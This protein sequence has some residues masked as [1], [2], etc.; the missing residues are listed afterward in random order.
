MV[1]IAHCIYV[2][3]DDNTP[4]IEALRADSVYHTCLLNIARDES[5]MSD[6]TEASNTLNTESVISLRVLTCGTLMYCPSRL[7]FGLCIY[8]LPPCRY[9]KEYITSTAALGRGACGSRSNN[10]PSI[11]WTNPFNLTVRRVKC[12]V[13]YRFPIS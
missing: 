11:P 8:A 3:S 9:L 7:R 1:G 4:V 10:H 12:C 6:L 13:Y 2:L 5:E